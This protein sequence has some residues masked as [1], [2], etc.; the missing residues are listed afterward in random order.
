MP[1]AKTSA[2]LGMDA[3]AAAPIAAPLGLGE[4]ARRKRENGALLKIEVCLEHD[5][6]LIERGRQ[7]FTLC[8]V[9]TTQPRVTGG[10][11]FTERRVDVD[12]LV[13]D[14]VHECL[15]R[16]GDAVAE[17]VVLALVVMVQHVADEGE[18]SSD[19]P[20]ALG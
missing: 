17:Q 11:D 1:M 19:G 14:L 8:P 20:R 13:L 2:D 5:M 3:A 10:G 4:H 16:C 18:M 15:R 9:R 7:R 6:Q 12:V